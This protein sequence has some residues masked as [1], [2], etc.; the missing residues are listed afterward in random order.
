MTMT[1][2]E[3]D[4][5]ALRRLFGRV[6][7]ESTLRTLVEWLRDL[8]ARVPGKFGATE[9][10]AMPF[11]LDTVLKMLESCSTLY[12]YRDRPPIGGDD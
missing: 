8:Y 1:A 5:A 6:G 9:D 2:T 11:W 10:G 3:E 7:L 12:A 4:L